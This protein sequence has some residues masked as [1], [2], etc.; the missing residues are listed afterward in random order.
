MYKININRKLHVK[1]GQIRMYINMTVEI[2][3][4]YSMTG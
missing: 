2:W 4:L 1:S 3:K